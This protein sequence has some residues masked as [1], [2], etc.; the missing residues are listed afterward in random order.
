MIAIISFNDYHSSIKFEGECCF[1]LTLHL[2][3]EHFISQNQ[4]TSNQRLFCTKIFNIVTHL[5]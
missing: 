3:R 1:Q 4:M 2:K 5:V